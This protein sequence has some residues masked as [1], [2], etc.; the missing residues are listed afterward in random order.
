MSNVTILTSGLFEKASKAR[1]I[2]EI[3]GTLTL[4]VNEINYFLS[5]IIRSFAGKCKYSMLKCNEFYVLHHLVIVQI[6]LCY[7]LK[8]F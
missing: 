4:I 2:C 5:T 6:L 3:I 8:F 1:I 7:L